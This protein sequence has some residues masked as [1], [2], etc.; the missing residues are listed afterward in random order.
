MKNIMAGI[1]AIGLVIVAL[2]L[3]FS[4]NSTTIISE[5]NIQR[6]VITV[7][8]QS[9][10]S[11]EPDQA[12]LYIKVRTEASTAIAAKDQNAEISDDV[13][14]ALRAEGVRKDDIESYQYRIYPN[15]KWNSITRDYENLGYVNEHI[16][17]VVTDDVDSVGEL[18][19]AA[20][21]AGA[22]GLDRVDFTLS[23]DY[24]ADVREQAMIIASSEA[25]QKAEVLTSN[26]G[27]NLGKITSISESSFYYRPY[28]YYGGAMEDV[29]MARA[30]STSIQPQNVD[31][32]GSVSLVYEIN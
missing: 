30:E 26:L 6:D 19:D 11:V 17:K 1:L 8:G 14:D 22:N 31:I 3:A 13:I 20:I 4:S 18:I 16:L 28:T 24:E 9:E 32:S 23:D 12:E 27:V 2:V 10:L 7:T 25:K 5:G 15:Q 21:D 29:A